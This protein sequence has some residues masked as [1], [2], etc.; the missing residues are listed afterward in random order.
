[1]IDNVTDIAIDPT[2]IAS[3]VIE[4]KQVRLTTT[5]GEQVM[6][7]IT[8]N[9][10]TTLSEGQM[11]HGC[12][13]SAANLLSAGRDGRNLFDKTRIIAD[14]EGALVALGK[15]KADAK[16]RVAAALSLWTTETDLTV[17]NLTRKALS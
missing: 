9:R 16:N 13:L 2:R 15:S 14:A 8:R 11:R 1:M 17:E 4:D 6:F 5:N 12:Y 3:M 10:M 7:L